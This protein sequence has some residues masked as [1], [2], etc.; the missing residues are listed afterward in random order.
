MEEESF[1]SCA[2]ACIHT[3]CFASVPCCLQKKPVAKKKRLKLKQPLR[4][5]V[6][7]ILI[8]GPQS[9]LRARDA[10]A[11][12]SKQNSDITNYA[13]LHQCLGLPKKGLT[14]LVFPSHSNTRKSVV[15][16]SGCR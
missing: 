7:T 2:P 6:K 11:A 12:S 15:F 16:P 4:N 9:N 13:L 8:L 5:Q 3:G 1:Y 10:A 14:P